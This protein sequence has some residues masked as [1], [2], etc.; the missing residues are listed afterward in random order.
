MFNKIEFAKAQIDEAMEQELYNVANFWR[1]ELSKH[2][3][4][5][6]IGNED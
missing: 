1:S 2:E 4:D 3:A 6:L 5:A